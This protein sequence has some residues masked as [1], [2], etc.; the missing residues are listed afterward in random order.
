MKKK[1]ST[2]LILLLHIKIYGHQIASKTLQRYMFICYTLYLHILQTNKMYAI[3][4]K[5]TCNE[6][7]N[8]YT[9]STS[10]R[11]VLIL[12]NSVMIRVWSC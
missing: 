7:Q 8:S 9:C 12:T 10:N 6:K 11:L 5:A 2:V 1:R 4:K 3:W